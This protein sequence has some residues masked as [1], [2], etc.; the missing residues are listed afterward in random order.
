MLHAFCVHAL[1][2][3]PEGGG[4]G[5]SAFEAVGRI[6]PINDGAKIG[7]MVETLTAHRTA[8]LQVG[9]DVAKIAERVE[10]MA[11]ELQARLQAVRKSAGAEW[12]PGGDPSMLDLRYFGEGETP[13]LGKRKVMIPVVN[14][15]GEI[16]T[17]ERVQH[18]LLTDPN[19]VTPQHERL[20]RAYIS[21]A[22]A[23]VL[24][25][26]RAGFDK[27]VTRTW[28][29]LRDAF[30]DLPGRTGE[31][32][33]SVFNDPIALKRVISNTAAS[34]GELIG[35]PTLGNVVRPTDL[36]R[37]IVGMVP[38]VEAPSAQFKKPAITGR[39]ILQRRGGTPPDPVRFPVTTFGTS[40]VTLSLVKSV[41]NVLLDADW[42][43][44]AGSILADPMGLIQKMIAEGVADSKEMM[45]LHGDT[46]GTHEDTLLTWT[47][48]GRYTAGVLDGTNSP[49]KLALGFRAEAF[50]RSATVAGG[51]TLDAADHFGALA[52]MGPHGANAR[53]AV[54]LYCFYTQFLANALFTT[55]DKAGALATLQTGQLGQ[56]GDT[57]ID[58]TDFLARE[59]ASTGLYTG[60]GTT[61]TAVYYKP[62]AY[63]YYW[64]HGD[65]SE[66]DVTHPET[67]AQ[68]VGVKEEGLLDKSVPATEVPAAAIINL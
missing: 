49:L 53:I 7:D 44:E 64:H 59:F 23:R 40:D 8:L 34:G 9:G 6:A 19:T 47:M 35:T 36:A 56:I 17:V 41:I 39:A 55:V 33:R 18:G 21:Y 57:P 5:G 22:M 20:R 3:S 62:E 12:V 24:G 58:L 28:L 1:C 67:G 60:S 2:M 48:G 16:E 30:C 31:W 52:L 42:A 51:G 37:R 13:R 29:S 46:A 26:K 14:G 61:S 65:N 15:Q 66:W 25:S 38:M 27:I 68:Y 45:F 11:P 43:S 63:T 10:R 32:A 54:G 50:D 4:G